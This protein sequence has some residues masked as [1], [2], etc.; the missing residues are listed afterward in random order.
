MVLDANLRPARWASPDAAVATVQGCVPGVVAAEVQPLRSA[1]AHRRATIL[2]PR[3]TRCSS[4][5][6]RSVVVT[7]GPDGALLRGAGGD[8]DVPGVPAAPV[9]TTGAGDAITGV[10]LARLTAADFDLAVLPR[11]AGRGGPGRRAR[12]RAASARSLTRVSDAQR[13]RAIRRAPGARSTAS[14]SWR[15]TRTRSASWS[16]PCC[17]QSTN[18]RN[19][20]VAFLRLRD[21]FPTLGGGARRAGRRDRGGDP[22]GRHLEGQVG[23]HQGDPAKR[24]ATTSDLDWMRDAPVERSRDYLVALPGVGRKTAACVLLFA[25]GLREVPF[26]THVSRVGGAPRDPARQGAV[27]EAARRDAADLAPGHRARAAR[28]PAA[29]RP[30]DLPRAAPGLRA[31]RRCGGCARRRSCSC[32]P[33]R[34]RNLR[35]VSRRRRR[36]RAAARRRCPRPSSRSW[37]DPA[38]RLGRIR[39]RRAPLDLGLPGPDRHVPRL[40][41]L[42]A[43]RLVNP[44]EVVEWN[45]DKR[46]LGELPRR[47][48]TRRF[49]APGDA[50]A[51]PAGEYVV[52]PSVS[53]GSRD[54]ARFAPGEEERAAALVERIHADGPHGDGPALRP[55]RRRRGRDGAA[56][57]RRRLQ[58][59]DPQGRRSSSRAPT[60]RRRLRAEKITPRDPAA[61]ERS[62]A[63]HIVARARE[64]FGDLAYT[65]VDLV[66][67]AD[68]PAAARARAH[69]AV[70]VLHARAGRS[71]ALRRGV[72]ITPRLTASRSR[73]RTCIAAPAATAAAASGT[74]RPRDATPTD[75]GAPG[76]RARP[77]PGCDATAVAR[78][79]SSSSTA[80]SCRPAVR[81]RRWAAGRC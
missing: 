19:R 74:P 51:A 71:G 20:D 8:R 24:S 12:D 63:E 50:F 9:D 80:N 58:P 40:G 2:P 75:A 42:G 81:R 18:D 44:P 62:L 13:V 22:P 6:A 3:R 64:R 45:T 37:D 25:Y 27:R 78:S 35:R 17:R 67:G 49:L 11:R 72:A 55:R 21:R 36:R 34:A 79:H 46:Y 39:P 16:S 1:G 30:A 53:A 70:A 26:D 41:P 73:L 61:E 14:R 5:G 47:A 33:H 57:L 65:R 68:G 66:P 77:R 54:T 38:G 60:P 48:S 31:L 52:K 29:P 43:A 4:L 56:V 76:R 32:D 69:R 10:L 28:Q 7:L 23:A 59:R 15:R